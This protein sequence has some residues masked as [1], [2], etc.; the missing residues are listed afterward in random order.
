MRITRHDNK[1]HPALRGM[2]LAAA[3]M[4]ALG[5]LLPAGH[6]QA[7]TH[8][9]GY[10]YN[11]DYWEDVQDSS[12]FYT[13]SKVFTSVDLGLDKNLSNPQ[14]M[15]VEGDQIFICDSGNNR[16]LELKRNGSDSL[17]LVR[18]IDSFKGGEGPETFSNP[19]DIAI[20]EDGDYF[21]ADQGNARVVKIDKDLNY[22]LQF[23]KPTDSALDAKL[24]FQPKKLVVDTAGR[25]YCIAVGINKGLCKY[26]CD[27]VF[28][29]FIGA[30][31]A[32]YN[33]WDYLWKKVASQEQ[34]QRM[35]AFVPTEYDNL[36]MDYEGF[37]YVVTGN[38]KEEG[39]KNGQVN[40]V[41]KLNLLGNDIL[42]RNGDYDNYG[43]LY[44]G[45]GGG[46]QGP[47]LFSDVTV[48]DNDVYMCLDRNRGRVFGYDDQGRMMFAFGGNGN[49]DGS[50]NWAIG[51]EH[52]GNN[53]YVLDQQSATLVTFSL[54]EF[55][56]LVF[57]AIEEFDH[58][59][60]DESGAIWEEVMKLNGNYDLAYIGI[61]RSL[62]RQ[63]KYHEAMEYFEVKYDDDNYSKA[64]KQYRKEWVED[65]IAIIVFIILVLFLVPMGIGRI[66]K[67]KH[68]IDTADI[69]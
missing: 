26:E 8:E 13:V 24:V 47:S 5:L 21:I 57:K 41:R 16:I 29:G 25:V 39:L 43:D 59:H 60:Y 28:S 27:G 32:T 6:V 15:T 33:L 53:L 38:V 45:D 42:V 40:A 65:H 10:T 67:I 17:E 49:E 4:V 23:L 56:E 36:Y 11:Y 68:D 69:F 48:L 31:P 37:I 14:G 7:A 34:L 35:T 66:R 51:L 19:T 58:G 55:G 1:L 3:G 22:K 20:S 64:Y 44:M 12:D 18:V 50:F 54:T 2:A 9:H 63:E 62:L 52:I 46:H 30:L 61:G